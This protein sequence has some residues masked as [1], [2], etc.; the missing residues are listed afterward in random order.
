MP[1]NQSEI[2]TIIQGVIDLQRKTP[3]DHTTGRFK[4][5]PEYTPTYLH[6][7]EMMERIQVHAVSGVLPDKLIAE[8]SPNQTD[9]EFQYVK[10]NYKQITYPVFIDLL[11][12]I[13]RAF[14]DNNWSIEYPEGTGEVLQE[15]LETGIKNTPLQMPFEEWM[16]GVLPSISMIDSMGCIAVRPWRI[17]TVEQNGEQVISGDAFEPIP[18]YFDSSQVVGYKEGEWY[19]FERK[20]HST[21]YIG[22]RPVQEGIIYEFYDKN[23]VWIITQVGAKKDYQ[24]DYLPFYTHDFNDVPVTRLKGNPQYIQSETIWQSPFLSVVDILDDAIMDACNLRGIKATCV[25]PY[26]VM[27]G[28]ECEYKMELNGETQ[29]CNGTG[30]FWDATASRHIQC[31]GCHGDGLKDRI[32]PYGVM[33]LRPQT[34]LKEGE[35]KATHPAMSYVEPS[36]ETPKFLREEISKYLDQ[37]RAIMHLRTSASEVKGSEDLTATGKALDERSKYAFIKGISDRLFSVAEFV[38]DFANRIL[39]GESAKEPVLNKPISFELKDEAEY[40]NDIGFAIERK[41]PP[42]VV[43]SIIYKYLQ[44]LF[45]NSG[46]AGAVFELLLQADRLLLTP[47]EDILIKQRSGLIADWEVI[48]H[49]SG[50]TL[51]RTIIRED[52]GFLKKE[53]GVQVETLVQRAKDKAAEIKPVG[54]TPATAQ[55]RIAQIL[56]Q[57]PAVQVA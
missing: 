13:Q 25:Y 37:A 55:G 31:P 46:D 48:L 45:Y 1:L 44:S 8:R 51:V 7:V 9:Q 50:I 16:K 32:S 42:F 19:L 4:K 35:I 5:L 26:R 57:P 52:P 6:S 12:T 40:L 27:V 20:D 24:F 47:T 53:I 14:F 54:Q 29:C 30:Q 41:V 2:Q 11:S 22:D 15:Y 39:N 18:Y 36:I 38:M 49:D 33:L 3:K 56:G 28:D 34:A 23:T 43:Q 21:V 10:R 17:P